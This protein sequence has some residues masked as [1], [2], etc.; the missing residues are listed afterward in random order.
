MNVELPRIKIVDF[1]ADLVD[2]FMA[3]HNDLEWMAYQGFKNLSKLE[4]EKALIPPKSITEGLQLAIL[5]NT[6]NELVGDLFILQETKNDC[7]VG[8]TV[9]P[10]FSRRGYMKEALQGLFIELKRRGITKIYADVD[11]RNIDSIKLLERLEFNLEFSK[12]KDAL[13]YSLSL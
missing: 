12:E 10:R 8:Y 2:D 5:N 11:E 3:Y 13:I 6:S 7:W 1:N 4:Y 9:N